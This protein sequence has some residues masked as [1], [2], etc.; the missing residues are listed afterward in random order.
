MS[1][2]KRM[3]LL[4]TRLIMLIV[5]TESSVGSGQAMHLK[6]PVLPTAVDPA[7]AGA[8]EKAV[9]PVMAM[10]VAEMLS[11]VPTKPFCRFCYCPNCH[12]GSQGSSIFSWNIKQPEQLTCKYC[13]LVFP[14]ADYPDD[15]IMAGKN[16]LGE[17]V[18]YQYHQDIKR[19]DLRM[20]FRAHILQHKRT[21]VLKQ[22]RALG[23]AY[24]ATNRPAYARR[25]ALI[26]D[27]I[28]QVY[29]HYPMV[30]QWITTFAFPKSQQPPFTSAGG[31][32]GRWLASELPA[33]L[34]ECY[35]LVY[36]SEEF[37]KLSTV[38]GYDVREKLE[39]DFFK[40]T[41][42]Y[43]NTFKSH[44]HNMAPSYL[45][46]AVKMGCVINEP[47]YV[48][49]AYGWLIKILNHGCFYD[50]MWHEAPSYH[51]QVMGGLRAAFEEL[52]GYTDPPGYTDKSDG[53]R[54]D[55]LDPD[56]DIRFFARAKDAPATVGFPNGFSSP[57]HDTWPNSRRATPRTETVSTI[58]PGYGH[59]SLGR[60]QGINQMQAQLHFS[61]GYGHTHL[62]NLNLT[63][64]A[65]GR[66]MLSDLGY[67]HTRLRRWTVSTI[68][69]NLVAIDRKDQNGS[70]SDGDLLRFF[71]DSNG[72]SVVEADGRRAYKGVKDLQMYRRLLMMVPTL[73]TDAYVVDIFRVAGGRVHD[74]LLHGSA[75][76]DMTARCSVP[77]TP[78]RKDLLEPG[79]EW[80]EPKTE[81]SRFNPYGVIR[82]VA[83]GKTSGGAE[84]TFTYADQPE[85]GVRIHLAGDGETELLLGRSP[86]IRGA[87][88]DSTKVWDYWM[89]HFVARRR[90]KAPLTSLFAAV[91][92][93]FAGKMFIESVQRVDLEPDDGNCV[94]L[95]VTHG[96]TVD[97]IISTLDEPP[98][99]ERTTPDGIRIKGQL[100]LIRKKKGEVTAMWLFDGTLI[101]NATSSLTAD[102]GRCAGNIIGAM[103]KADGDAEDAFLIDTDPASGQVFRGTWM[104]VTHGNGYKHGY[105]IDRA[106]TREG[107]TW[108]VLKNDHGLRIE[109]TKTRELFF[110]CREMDGVNTFVIPLAASSQCRAITAPAGPVHR[111]PGRTESRPLP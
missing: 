110:P 57:I 26:L 65:K 109:G 27:R 108:V 82:D 62:D 33:G 34:P 67:T 72:V 96:D 50:G 73:S 58:C 105:E 87:K 53:T 37:D 39:N 81:G 15:Q 97:T 5:L 79:E 70:G 95:R 100:G 47:S 75:N 91:E 77:L 107:K 32:W 3:V 64:F 2:P 38:R 89:P 13:G 18:T 94:G 63:L 88:S 85:N 21:W 83:P 17:A 98:Y 35:D 8:Y 103:R 25:S 49:W 76:H 31:K 1:F 90:G 7:D 84:V 111:A 11:F 40:A 99:P 59:A 78:G 106:E 104:I 52:R 45:R 22:C 93:A 9:A 28:A 69:H 101:A 44:D 36:D 55:N 71:P 92:E 19:Q 12:G 68:S 86:S 43:V 6:H 66:E 14:N 42:E 41:F 23:R 46:V 29:P 102:S 54:F 61:G 16:A 51:Y 20:F 60:G 56:Q 4:C 80:A 24:Q 48:H 30:R 74:W 10:S